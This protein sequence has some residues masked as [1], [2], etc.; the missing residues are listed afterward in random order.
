MSQICEK[1]TEN[2]DFEVETY[3]CLENNVPVHRHPINQKLTDE[4]DAQEKEQEKLNNLGVDKVKEWYEK[5]LKQREE[6]PTQ[7]LP[8]GL[9]DTIEEVVKLEGLYPQAV[10]S[11]FLAASAISTQAGFDVVSAFRERM[12]LSL[13]F[14]T[15][16]GPGR[17]KSRIHKLA[18]QHIRDYQDMV[19]ANRDETD[20]K[21]I[22]QLLVSDATVEAITEKCAGD[23]KY[24]SLCS[25]E[26][27][28]VLEGYSLDE[29]RMAYALGVYN[30]LYETES[31]D[32]LRASGRKNIPEGYRFSIHL[33]GQPMATFPFLNTKAVKDSG[34]LARFLIVTPARNE[35]LLASPF[36]N[37]N[38]SDVLLTYRTAMTLL[39]EQEGMFY[40]IPLSEGATHILKSFDRM[41]FERNTDRGYLT[42]A[43]EFMAKEV[44]LATKLSCICYLVDV[45]YGFVKRE[46]PFSSSGMEVPEVF[47]EAGC[48]LAEYYLNEQMVAM[49]IAHMSKEE[50]AEILIYEELK[51]ME[52]GW[53][54]K[55]AHISLSGVLNSHFGNNNIQGKDELYYIEKRLRSL[56][57]QG[58]V[59]VGDAGSPDKSGKWDIQNCNLKWTYKNS[60]VGR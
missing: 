31:S 11:G 17:R 27:I 38:T 43:K 28:R 56:W 35:G 3:A 10:A 51:T 26:A 54:F 23:D 1:N 13:Y 9:R 20:E 29:K 37:A 6:F 41:I 49:D 36:G 25:P 39:L 30:S 34:L 47:A 55:A 48:A 50:E 57:N 42:S 24:F 59:G 4:V 8:E 40:K 46:V 7:V 12:N 14:L 18:F 52:K 2:E 44:S 32:V 22:R 16:C 19:N 60:V 33:M 5:R 21:P 45:A 58:V 15:I 53:H